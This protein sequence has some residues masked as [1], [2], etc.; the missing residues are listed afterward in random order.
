MATL[1]RRFDGEARRVLKFPPTSDEGTSKRDGAAVPSESD[2]EEE[3]VEEDEDDTDQQYPAADDKYKGLEDKLAAMEIQKVPG[4]EFEESGLVSGIV[5][6]P[7]FKAPVFS[8]YDGVSC[9][10]MHL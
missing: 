1:G 7:K 4:L 8:K 9:P 3:E 5:I 10:K 2:A 6:P